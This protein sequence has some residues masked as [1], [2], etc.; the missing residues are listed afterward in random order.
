M[1]S[2]TYRDAKNAVRVKVNDAVEITLAQL[3]STALLNDKDFTTYF[4]KSRQTYR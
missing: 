1:P 4:V 3:Q 2:D